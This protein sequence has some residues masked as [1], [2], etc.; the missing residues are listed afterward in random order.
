LAFGGPERIPTGPFSFE[1]LAPV[2][3]WDGADAVVAA[4][5]RA[6]VPSDGVPLA[7]VGAPCRLDAST[8]TGRGGV[9]LDVVAEDGH[10][11]YR[12]KVG[13]YEASAACGASDL[14]V[15]ADALRSLATFAERER[16]P[17]A[18]AR[19]RSAA[20]ALVTSE[21]AAMRPIVR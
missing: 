7:P 16:D 4:V 8:L 10:G 13:A 1:G 18:S 11:H 12:V 21:I 17:A 20:E 19:E 15:D 2:A 6:R 5:D 14:V 3:S 9:V